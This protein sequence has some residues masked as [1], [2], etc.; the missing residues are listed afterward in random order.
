MKFFCRRNSIFISD[1]KSRHKILF[2]I[3]YSV[4]AKFNK[5][6][7][8]MF[9][10]DYFEYRFA[11][12][13]AI[14]LKSLQN[15]TDR[16][17]QCFLYHSSEMPE[18]LKRRFLALENE[19]PFL[20]NIFQKGSTIDVPRAAVTGARVIMTI[21]IDN[22]DG[23]P[24]DFVARLRPYCDEKFHGMA[25]SVPSIVSLKKNECGMLSVKNRDY[26]SNSIGLAY[27]GKDA[28]KNIFDI[29]DH[30]KVRF[31]VPLVLVPGAGGLQIINYEN[32]C[33]HISAESVGKWK[34]LSE[35]KTKRVLRKLNYPDFDFE[36]LHPE[37]KHAKGTE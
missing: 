23:L 3:R 21:R 8:N 15:Q 25:I 9:A 24:R 6:G 2:L 37:R 20:K 10:P 28:S 34:I 31:S 4:R 12:F 18:N 7:Q 27:V 5:N 13:S 36:F 29:A 16:D 32:V 11:N 35:N 22:D 33:N 14:T 26:I 30:T 1:S 19:N 17:F